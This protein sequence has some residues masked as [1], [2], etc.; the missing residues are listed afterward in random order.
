MGENK[1]GRPGNCSQDLRWLVKNI[2]GPEGAGRARKYATREEKKKGRAVAASYY[3][4]K[5]TGG[6]VWIPELA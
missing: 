4:K 2:W 3:E 1:G 5:Y 6:G